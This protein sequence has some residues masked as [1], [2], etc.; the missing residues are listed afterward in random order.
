M[1]PGKVFDKC[2]ERSRIMKE[3]KRPPGSRAVAVVAVAVWLLM[4][5]L[6]ALL[7]LRAARELGLGT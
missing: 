1:I 2:R 5:A 6:G 4:A 3:G 7:A